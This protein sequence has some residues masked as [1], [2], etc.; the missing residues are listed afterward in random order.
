MPQSTVLCSS[1]MAPQSLPSTLFFGAWSWSH[2][3]NLSVILATSKER[4]RL[5]RACAILPAAEVCWVRRQLAPE[6]NAAEFVATVVKLAHVEPSS[7]AQAA[8]RSTLG[9]LPSREARSERSRV[10]SRRPGFDQNPV[11][12]PTKLYTLFD[13]HV[14]RTRKCW[15]PLSSSWMERGQQ[16][17]GVRSTASVSSSET[18][19]RAAVSAGRLHSSTSRRGARS[20]NLSSLLG[21]E[22]HG[23]QKDSALSLARSSHS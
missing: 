15:K 8:H 1:S 18:I 7:Q 10:P 17:P 16:E 11:S 19:R 12:V 6:E 23:P 14:S 2:W 13:Q 3:K 5:Q 9:S 21:G 22:L 4:A 20:R